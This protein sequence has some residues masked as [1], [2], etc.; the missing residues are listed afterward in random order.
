MVI[1]YCLSTSKPLVL[2][3]HRSQILTRDKR[4]IG[5]LVVHLTYADALSNEE[6]NNLIKINEE[7]IRLT[8]ETVSRVYLVNIFPIRALTPNPIKPFTHLLIYQSNIFLLGYRVLGS[9]GW[10]PTSKI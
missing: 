7:A 8:A 9:S 10:L 5:K 2:D 1:H 4:A 6:A 3:F